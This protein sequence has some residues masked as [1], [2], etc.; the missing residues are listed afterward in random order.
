MYNHIQ[1]KFCPVEAK[2]ERGIQAHMMMSWGNVHQGKHEGGSHG[3]REARHQMEKNRKTM[4]SWVKSKLILSHFALGCKPHHRVISPWVNG[5]F[6]MSLYRSFNNC[7]LW[8][9]GRAFCSLGEWMGQGIL[10]G[11]KQLCVLPSR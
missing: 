5:A 9:V 3:G 4:W 2:S 10:Q 7:S 8:D 11:R 1:H 6:F